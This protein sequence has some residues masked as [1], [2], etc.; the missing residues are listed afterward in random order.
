MKIL[1][2]GGGEVGFHLARILTRAGHRIIIIDNSPERIS[3]LETRL[4][5]YTL[6]G[7]GCE[8]GVLEQAGA[9]SADVI[10]AVT[11]NDEVNL[12]AGYFAKEIGAKRAIVRVQ[13]IS[14]YQFHRGFYQ[15]ALK[16]DY[17]LSPRELTAQVIIEA[18]LG[19]QASVVEDF[20]G[21]KIQLRQFK[22][23]ARL[24]WEG[25][26]LSQ[27]NLPRDCLIVALIKNQPKR[28]IIIPDGSTRIKEGDE[29]LI[30]G[31]PGRV[32]EIEKTFGK[33]IE[34]ARKVILVGGGGL[35]LAIAQKL[36]ASEIDLKLIEENKDRADELAEILD[37]TQIINGNGTDPMLLEEL[38][39]K[40]TDLF[41]SACGKDEKNL[42]G[43]QL[44]KKLGAKKVIALVENPEYVELY[45]SL[46]ID[47]AVCPRRLLAEKIIGFINTGV[48][49]SIAV[50]EEGK[51]EVIEMR[52]EEK[53]P[54]TKAPL[55]QVGFPKGAII[56]VI[57][58]DGQVLIPTGKDQVK[59][60]DICIV[61]SFLKSLPQ[62]QKLFAPSN[63]SK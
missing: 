35:G 7:N 2:I 26:T 60:G 59:P 41:I 40:S 27:A 36:E 43:C 8:A 46:G 62:V 12:L 42:L 6:L 50:I 30:L 5:V 57:V 21:G 24:P 15:R 16:Y 51:A 10:L 48:V 55:S 63:K 47:L 61:F 49:G 44:A 1:I 19:H 53:S 9:F 37:Q 56:G 45:E 52:A 23:P 28:E 4:D 18:V 39:I 58:R 34:R 25:K 38:G 3:E 32:K 14:R 20:A 13:N 22:I 29:V 54:V 17:M 33:S 11:S 31:S